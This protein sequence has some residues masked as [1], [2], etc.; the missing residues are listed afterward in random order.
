MPLVDV[1]G[2]KLGVGMDSFQRESALTVAEESVPSEGE[3]GK[4]RDHWSDLAGA[5]W[6]RE[7]IIGSTLANG[8]TGMV[9]K[10]F[11]KEDPDHNPLETLEGTEWEPY[12]DRFVDSRSQEETDWIISKIQQER[13]DE[14]TI[15][16]AGWAGLPLGL[17]V[18]M[19]DPSIIIPGAGLAKTAK[20]GYSVAKSAAMA[21]ASVGGIVAGQEAVLQGT[22]QNRTASESAFNITG[23]MVLGG[24]LGAGVAKLSNKSQL[25]EIIE[26]FGRKVVEGDE[27][28]YT[29]LAPRGAGAEAADEFD[30]RLVGEKSA[31]AVNWTSPATYLM[32]HRS[33]VARNAQ[34]NLDQGGLQLK[35]NVAGQAAEFEGKGGG[36]VLNRIKWWDG[37]LGESI[38][39]LDKLFSKYY[40]GK[41]VAGARVRSELSRLTGK[42]SKLT[43]RQFNQQVSHALRNGDTHHIPEVQDAARL[44]R[45]QIF[46]P[47]KK[48][49]IKN[50]QLPENVTA[51][52]A[53]SY[54]TRIYKIDEI[55]MNE[56]RFKSRLKEYFIRQDPNEDPNLVEQAVSDVY[57][58]ITG[59]NFNRS[60]GIDMYPEIR[61]SLKER[62]LNIPDNE[63][64]EFLE[65]DI[66]K[67]I[68]QYVRTMA[69]D[70]ELHS[71]FGSVE[72]KQV[73]DDLKVEREQVTAKLT[74]KAKIKADKEFDLA[75]EKIAAQ[76]DRLR[77]MYAIP[78]N[79]NNFGNKLLRTALALNYLRLLG[80]M[81]I[82]ALP[83]LAKPVM[84]Q[85]LVR[86]MRTVGTV[87]SDFKNFKLATAEVKRAGTAWDL[88]LDTRTKSMAD[89][90]SDWQMHGSG[91]ERGLHAATQKFGVVSLMAPWNA[92]MKQFTGV[93][94]TD[95]IV[96]S[97]RAWAKG[98]IGKAAKTK[99]AQGGINEEMAKRIAKMVDENDGGGRFQN[100]WLTN[101]SNWK[102]KEAVRAFHA[103]IVEEV[104]RAIVTPGL[105][106]PLFMSKGWGKLIGQFRSFGFSSVQKTLMAGLQRH[107][108]AFL[109]GI[110]LATTLGAGTSGMKMYVA[111]RST[112]DWEA[113][114]WV[115]EGIDRSGVLGIVADVNNLAERFTGNRLGMA[116]LTGQAA[117]RFQS[118]NEVA[119]LL[120]PSLGLGQD[121]VDVVQAVAFEGW[122][123]S[124]TR[125]LRKLLPFQ[126]LFY[127]RQGLNRIEEAA[128]D[129]FDIPKT[130]PRR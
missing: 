93:M 72:M 85:G 43:Q 100:L 21:S 86:T 77:G 82:S 33:K 71:R 70:I 50:G 114:K 123:Q 8:I 66:E 61:G 48:Q 59:S 31:K 116:A 106:K 4:K 22:Q 102:D 39:G 118:R 68:N 69:P 52:G 16:R 19:A 117:S 25:E 11:F 105:E 107:D 45:D 18:G 41:K 96:R 119:A 79:P 63:I 90:Y 95:T 89:M 113:G 3:F 6:R 65:D 36:S 73:F 12:L 56:A 128:N 5:Y 28:I 62:V 125:V 20:G 40:F 121:V 99:L 129:Y 35:G 51:K 64:A 44:V 76:R 15:A 111:G 47:I 60:V 38:E 83:D 7:N 110:I 1:D 17:A 80:G 29:G 126:N 92:A 30:S 37:R 127:I 34:A 14:E 27:D 32:G 42:A 94:V 9:P 75:A 84:E 124:N 26:D 91:F 88:I 101:T 10:A 74:G 81:T 78:E 87:F 58:N 13:A 2:P 46:E 108:A 97:S 55:R 24:F 53:E 23:A 54:L 103:A 104:D 120:G 130:K 112:E 49:A 115:A 67:V 57:N 122:S 109:N 98:T